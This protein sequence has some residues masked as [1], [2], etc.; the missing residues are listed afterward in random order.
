MAPVEHTTESTFGAS[1]QAQ[2]R[3]SSSSRSASWWDAL[4]HFLSRQPWLVATLVLA[5]LVGIYLIS[6]GSSYR[7]TGFYLDDW[8][9]LRQLTFGPQ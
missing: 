2:K 6:F 7:K 5:I 3:K 1:V 8:L 9:M 4:A